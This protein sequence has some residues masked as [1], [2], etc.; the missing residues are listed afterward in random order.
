MKARTTPNASIE[1]T[2]KGYLMKIPAG[3]SS[4]YRFAQI[5]DYFGL[6]VKSFRITH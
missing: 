5:D 4:A 3:D 2:E 1:K 6:P